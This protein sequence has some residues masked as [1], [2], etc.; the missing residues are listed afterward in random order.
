M[1]AR[2]KVKDDN[3]LVTTAVNVAVFFILTIQN[4]GSKNKKY[5]LSYGL[6]KI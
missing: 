2:T 1:K 4:F 5:Y 3:M 6:Y